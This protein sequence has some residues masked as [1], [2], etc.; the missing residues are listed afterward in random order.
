MSAATPLQESSQPITY[1]PYVPYLVVTGVDASTVNYNVGPSK[2][3]TG[4]DLPLTGK[5]TTEIL[6]S[7][8][9]ITYTSK[10]LLNKILF[11]N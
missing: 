1:V 10:L 8:H 5:I 4:S 9:F 7:F 6:L 2:D 11:Y 3:P